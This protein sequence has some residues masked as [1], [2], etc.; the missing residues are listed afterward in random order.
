MLNYAGITL[1][2][3]ET[4]RQLTSQPDYFIGLSKRAAL[5]HPVLYY[6]LLIGERGASLADVASIVGLRLGD[7]SYDFTKAA[8]EGDFAPRGKD[9][10]MDCRIE[11]RQTCEYNIS[12]H[13][14]DLMT[15][16]S[17]SSQQRLDRGQATKVYIW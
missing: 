14:A 3:T 7:R 13:T 8:D 1:D 9:N 10:T 16:L 2:D 17:F 12:S 15:D 5:S 6:D 11:R 4:A